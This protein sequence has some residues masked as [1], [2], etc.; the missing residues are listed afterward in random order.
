ML[1]VDVVYRHHSWVGLDRLIVSLLPKLAWNFLAS[2]KLVLREG[3][4]KSIPAQGCLGPASKMHDAFRNRDFPSDYR[5][6]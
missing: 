2:C 4:F 5:G 6:R 3:A 1:I